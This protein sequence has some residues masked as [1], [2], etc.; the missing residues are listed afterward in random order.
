MANWIQTWSGGVANL[1]APLAVIDIEE[2]AHVLSQTC[3]F[4]GHTKHFYSVAQHSVLVHQI[5][6]NLFPNAYKNQQLAALLHD[7]HEAYWGFGDVSTPAKNLNSKFFESKAAMW[8]QLIA[9]HFGFQYFEFGHTRIKEAD[10]IALA[11][12]KRDLMRTC[13]IP[14]CKNVEPWPDFINPLSPFIAE[15][16]FLET[17]A[18]IQNVVRH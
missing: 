4:S 13:V 5:F 10:T 16:L 14:W 3:R 15:E 9:D 8:D 2:I 12:E 11:T 17:F 1:D 6:I 18:E 7:A